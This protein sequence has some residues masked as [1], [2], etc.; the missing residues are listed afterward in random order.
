MSLGGRKDVKVPVGYVNN[1]S[2][3]DEIGVRA[4]IGE[5]ED[6]LSNDNISFAKRIDAMVLNCIDKIGQVTDKAKIAEI[7][8]E[9]TIED[10]TTLLIQLRAMSIS[11]TLE[12]A[13]QCPEC[14][15]PILFKL[16]LTS[17]K[18]TPGQ[19]KE[20][21]LHEIQL[22][23]GRKCKVKPMQIKDRQRIGQMETTGEN[24][25]SVSI[26]VRLVELDGKPNPTFQDV[27]GMMYGDRLALRAAFDRIEGSI[28]SEFNIT[29]QA[30]G[31]KFDESLD[32]ANPE[33][34]LPKM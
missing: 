9:L 25:M 31:A 24:F 10:Q 3:T 19:A 6:I 15:K 33:F 29:C 13:M 7:Y 20:S 27:R 22:P 32:I 1:G 26:W 23:S 17:L 5:E 8:P 18:V 4:M 21:F 12:Y 34:L 28:E 14:K 16:D 2:S 30:C 11:E